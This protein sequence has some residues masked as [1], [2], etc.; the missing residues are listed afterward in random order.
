MLCYGTVSNYEYLLPNGWSLNSTTSNGSTW[1]AGDNSE[2]IT[3]DLATGDGGVV[4]IRPINTACGTNLNKGREVTIPI[5][6]PAP[7]LSIT[8]QDFLCN[9]GDQTTL[10][11]NG[12]PSG[13]SVSWGV[14]LPSQLQ[15]VGCTTCTSVML[16]KIGSASTTAT[17]TATVTHCSFTYTVTKTIKLG[18]PAGIGIANYNNLDP[19]PDEGYFRVMETVQPNVYDYSGSLTI[20]TTGA[21]NTISWALAPGAS[22]NGWTWTASGST[23]TVSTKQDYSSLRLRVTATND[24]GSI[25]KDYH[26]RSTECLVLSRIA[27]PEY[28]V[29]PNP[30]KGVFTIS[31]KGSDKAAAIKEIVVK[32]KVGV[33]VK[34]FKYKSTQKAQ[35]VNIQDL[36]SDVYFVHIFDGKIWVGERIFKE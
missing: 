10:T 26:F 32:N 2:T 24:C 19:C 23:V 4:R 29:H 17:A 36:P 28:T 31:L 16:E 6:R 9:A 22:L 35:T 11:I 12:L 21:A 3:Y 13:A 1:I 25:N 18:A 15:P 14:S 7:V 30:T 33:A 5:S 8:G 20:G 34:Q 27:S